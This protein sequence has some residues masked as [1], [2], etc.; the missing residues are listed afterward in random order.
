[1]NTIQRTFISPAGNGAPQNAMSWAKEIDSGRV[2]PL[3]VI[4][5]CKLPEKVVDGLLVR[6]YRQ[7][8]GG[9]PCGA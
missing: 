7:S 1:M 4:S 3:Q 8:S 5:D 6:A 2:G 9:T